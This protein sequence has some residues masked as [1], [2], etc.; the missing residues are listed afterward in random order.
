MLIVLCLFRQ[1]MSYSG[2]WIYVLHS[3][4]Q[5]KSPTL[6]THLENIDVPSV[7]TQS[8]KKTKIKRFY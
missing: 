4:L 1:L 3:N 6:S 2:E 5:K 7:S 8:R